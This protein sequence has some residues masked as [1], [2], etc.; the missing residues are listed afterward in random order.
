[1]ADEDRTA[2]SR[3]LVARAADEEHRYA[4]HP[5]DLLRNSA[6][7]GGTEDTASVRR[8]HKTRIATIAQQADHSRRR[9]VG[10]HDRNLDPGGSHRA[11]RVVEPSRQHGARLGVERG[12]HGREHQAGVETSAQLS[13]DRD[14][15][16]REVGAVEGHDEG[17]GH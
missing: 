2:P 7:R 17:A 12:R 5:H 4:R 1:M 3:V 11:R 15:P 16:G 8:H 6:Q 9:I 13:G 14:R 10:V